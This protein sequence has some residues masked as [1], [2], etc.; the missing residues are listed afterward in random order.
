VGGMESVTTTTDSTMSSDVQ[1]AQSLCR[2][3]GPGEG[4]GQQRG[5]EQER[6]SSQEHVLPFYRGICACAEHVHIRVV[7]AMCAARLG[8]SALARPGAAVCASAF[9]QVL[10]AVFFRGQEETTMAMSRQNQFVVVFYRR[11]TSEKDQLKESF[12]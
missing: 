6:E 1:S 2:R 12:C 7:R 3:G 11:L 9:L 5:G 8:K 4:R 10:V